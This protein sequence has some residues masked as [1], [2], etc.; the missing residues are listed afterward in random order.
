MRRTH[1]RD[2]ESVAELAR[3]VYTWELATGR[4]GVPKDLPAGV[5]PTLLAA[6]TAVSRAL[7]NL[8]EAI[9]RE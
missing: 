2:I 8:D 7:L 5:S 3:N 6:Y 4:A 9:T 1:G